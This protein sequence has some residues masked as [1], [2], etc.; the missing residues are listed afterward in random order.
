MNGKTIILKCCI[1]GRERTDAGW[2]YQYREI[3]Q[4]EAISH[5]LCTSCFQKEL[6]K[7]KMETQLISQV[8]V[9]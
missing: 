9:R 3:Q 5:A 2:Q 7:V 1:C 8:M 6:M 4:T